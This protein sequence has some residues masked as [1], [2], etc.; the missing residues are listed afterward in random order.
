MS[1][2]L[3]AKAAATQWTY[4]AIAETARIHQPSVAIETVAGRKFAS[5]ELAL[6]ERRQ[7]SNRFVARGSSLGAAI[8]IAGQGR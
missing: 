4:Q 6:A 2:G 5:G 7:R 8:T 1:D 3:D